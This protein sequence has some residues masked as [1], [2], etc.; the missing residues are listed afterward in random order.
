MFAPPVTHLRSQLKMGPGVFILGTVLFTDTSSDTSLPQVSLT[1]AQ[2][3]SQ[4]HWHTN[5]RSTATAA[6]AADKAAIQEAAEERKKK[7]GLFTS[8]GKTDHKTDLS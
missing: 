8:D 1:G 4:G 7:G 6:A 5:T 3:R 2:R